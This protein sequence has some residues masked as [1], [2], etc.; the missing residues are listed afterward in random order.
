ME[1]FIWLSTILPKHIAIPLVLIF[2]ILWLLNF[3][4]KFAFKLELK[5]NKLSERQFLVFPLWFLLL[6]V[7]G[8]SFVLYHSYNQEAELKGTIYQL[9]ETTA[10]LNQRLREYAQGANIEITEEEL[11]LPPVTKNDLCK[12]WDYCT[13][14]KDDTGLENKYYSHSKEDPQRLLLESNSYPGPPIYF[15][16]ETS[17][18][19][20]FEL[21][22]LPLNNDAANIF[23][24]SKG[25][26]QLFIGDSDYRSLA[27]LRW[28]QEESR[29][30]RDKEES[31]I[32][33]GRDLNMPDIRP[34]SQFI[35]SVETRKK[36]NDAEAIFSIVYESIE[37]TKKNA[38]FKKDI[39]LPTPK[40][41]DFLT[42]VGT[43]MYI[44]KGA[45]SQAKFQFMGVRQK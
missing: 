8:I 7:I 36:N 40:P 3:F 43:G 18:F 37:G 33:L 9:R 5:K 26:F 10:Q 14:F 42:K 6:Y 1:G 13:D 16:N 11:A 44:L 35:I 27:F 32:F 21:N 17:P 15:E 34:K 2:I 31:K 29:W 30:I 23:I 22:V 4:G 39:D 19:Y 20:Y 25:M 28:N 41:E 45:V 12:E 24:E 38:K